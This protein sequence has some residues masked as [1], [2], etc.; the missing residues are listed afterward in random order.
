M[1]IRLCQ[2][3]IRK[4]CAKN[5]DFAGYSSRVEDDRKPSYQPNFKSILFLEQN[6]AERKIST[7]GWHSSR[8]AFGRLAGTPLFLTLNLLFA[9]AK[10]N[11]TM[12]LSVQLGKTLSFVKFVVEWGGVG[13]RGGLCILVH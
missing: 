9:E 11:K 1:F 2:R 3:G 6:N 10:Q 13:W 8:S 5:A 7:N 12:V 4:R